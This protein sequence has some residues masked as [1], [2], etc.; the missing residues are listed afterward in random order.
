M[1]TG[2]VLYFLKS[3]NKKTGEIKITDNSKMYPN[4]YRKATRIIDTGSMINELEDERQIQI[5]P[6]KFISIEIFRGYNICDNI[7]P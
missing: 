4:N 2:I 3:F 7:L 6:F 1:F 5:I